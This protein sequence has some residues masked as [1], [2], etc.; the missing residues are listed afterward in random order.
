MQSTKCPQ[1]NL[2]NFSGAENCKRCSFDL[3]AAS[4]IPEQNFDIDLPAPE[5]APRPYQ[6][7][8]EIQHKQN[9]GEIV[10]AVFWILYLPYLGMVFL[11]LSAGLQTANGAPQQAAGAAMAAAYAIIPYCGLRAL[12]EAAKLFQG[13]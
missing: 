8:V 12:S 9:A 7:I 5:E 1:C 6:S 11:S 4:L 10:I 2:V 3:F 13:K